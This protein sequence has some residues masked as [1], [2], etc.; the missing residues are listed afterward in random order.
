MFFF[1]FNDLYF[2]PDIK[3]AFR[4]ICLDKM[5]VDGWFD[6]SRFI[7]VRYTKEYMLFN[8]TR[9]KSKYA[10]LFSE[11]YPD[12][13]NAFKKWEEHFGDANFDD[14]ADRLT[15]FESLS[16][17]YWVYCII[18]TVAER[19]EFTIA[20]L[21][22]IKDFYYIKNKVKYTKGVVYNEE[23]VKIKFISSTERFLTLLPSLNIPGTQ[24]FFRGHSVANYLLYP[25][26]MRK[27]S[28]RDNEHEMYNELLINCPREFESCKTHLEVLVKMQHYGLP[29][30]LLDITR[31]PLVALYF[32][33]NNQ[34]ECYGEVILL[35]VAHNE[36]KY[37]QSDTASILA[38]LP[39]F[40]HDEQNVFQTLAN[41]AELDC[42][43]LNNGLSRLLHE[44]RQE[45][46]AFKPEIKK[47]DLLG[48]CIVYA[49]KNNDRIIKQDG[50]FILCGLL[51]SPDSLNKFK[52]RQ[53]GKSVVILV[54]NKEKIL[55][56]LNT[57]GI[58]YAS[59]FPEIECVAE[60]IKNKFD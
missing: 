32:S 20:L 33:C 8:L 51:E 17:V 23:K 7:H 59:L 10:I 47:E 55:E 19:R 45:K 11:R 37:P 9:N 26:I 34:P 14:N 24:L 12:P 22:Q 5:L 31:N 58:C 25:S 50:A 42:E 18:K 41:D 29:T 6:M 53:G 57:I 54:D 49:L 3:Q 56:Q 46:P 13:R 35:A 60:S 27:Q 40:S 38:C 30:R 28:W 52:Y 48:S 15:E 2:I 39:Q 4:N 43:A 36:I 44:I 21:G 16:I 1:F